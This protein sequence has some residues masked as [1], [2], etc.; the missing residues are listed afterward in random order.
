MTYVAI[1]GK[2]CI[3]HCVMIILEALLHYR[4]IKHTFPENLAILEALSHLNKDTI[5]KIVDVLKVLLIHSTYNTHGYI[6]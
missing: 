6:S 2:P 5:H 1:K 4:C 3:H